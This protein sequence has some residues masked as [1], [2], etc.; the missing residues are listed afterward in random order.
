MDIAKVK[1]IIKK[2]ISEIKNQG[3]L[4]ENYFY[5]TLAQLFNTLYYFLIFPFSIKLFGEQD[6]GL[7][8]YSTTIISFFTLFISFG[9]DMPAL[10]ILA[11]NIE[12]KKIKSNLLSDVLSTKILLSFL[13]L[14]GLIVVSLLNPELRRLLFINSLQ[15]FSSIFLL[16]WYYQ[17]L[18]KMK[19]FVIPQIAI[20]IISMVLLFIFIKNK[21]DL[22]LYS[23]IISGSVFLFS[24]LSFWHIVFKEGLSVRIVKLDRIFKF[25]KKA[26]HFFINSSI[27]VVRSQSTNIFVG[28]YVGM[29][30]VGYFDLASKIILLPQS[31]VSNINNALFPKLLVSNGIDRIL[32]K[33]IFLLETILGFFL[34]SLVVFFGDNVISI[35]LK[36]NVPIVHNLAILLSVTI[37]SYLLVGSAVNFVFIPRDRYDIISKN[38]IIA[39]IT[40]FLSSFI[41]IYFLKSVYVIAFSVALSA[42]IEILYC[43]AMVVK[44]RI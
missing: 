6:F 9:I 29:S 44:L 18:Q 7:F 16:S 26:Y 35:F 14:C 31:I 27:S 33:K 43:F 41:G 40:F 37:L 25:I 36:E 22:L 38:Q 20:R 1:F 2:K 10:R 42:I 15:A 13:S 19:W 39:F 23:L 5:L 30:E 24:I 11:Q 34:V 21:D 3:V 4:I 32:L 12:S 8:I 17:G 28:S